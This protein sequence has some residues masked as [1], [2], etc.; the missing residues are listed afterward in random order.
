MV[1]LP[2]LANSTGGF[3][4]IGAN[5]GTWSFHALKIF[6]QSARVRAERRTGRCSAELAMM[7]Q[8]KVSPR[9]GSDKFRRE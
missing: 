8:E 6:S 2:L 9:F 1:L 4:D 7:G 3:L 5:L